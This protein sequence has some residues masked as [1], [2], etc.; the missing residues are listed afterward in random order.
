MISQNDILTETIKTTFSD[1]YSVL[2]KFPKTG[3]REKTRE[4]HFVRNLK[5]IKGDAALKFLFLLDQKF[6]RISL[7]SP[8]DDLIA[9]MSEAI[10]ECVDKFASKQPIVHNSDNQ[11]ITNSIKNARLKRDQL[12]DYRKK[13]KSYRNKVTHMIREA[14][15]TDNFKK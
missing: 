11:W 13:Y 5:T 4:Q 6:K 8:V 9:Q 1:H 14:K 7:D 2:A 3:R 15:R 12:Y 10:M